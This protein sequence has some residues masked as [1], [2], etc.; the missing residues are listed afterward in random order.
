MN[1][2]DT[3]NRSES[4]DF[5]A[6]RLRQLAA[7]QCDEC[8]ADDEAAE[9]EVMLSASAAARTM[10]VR[11]MNVHAGLDW[12]I[13]SRE[14]VEEMVPAVEAS[15]E[16]LPPLS[17]QRSWPWA[18][19]AIAAGLLIVSSV[20][21]WHTK[22]GAEGSKS[23]IADTSA[24]PAGVDVAAAVTE[25]GPQAKWSVARRDNDAPKQLREGD[26]VSISEGE[27]QVRFDSGVVV[28]LYAPAELE[29]ISPMK[30]KAIRGR[31][32][33]NVVDGAEGFAI[34]T[35]RATV[36][37]QGTVFGV[38]VGD[39]GDTDV[40]VFKGAV[41]LHLDA[42]D[43]AEPRLA[44]Q[45][46]TSGEAMRIDNHGTT[47]RIVSISSDRF[48]NRPD[49]HA[50][51]V[52]RPVLISAVSDNIERGANSWNYYEIV[53]GG[54]NEDAKAFVDRDEHEWN[55]IDPSGMPKFLIGGDYVKTFNN[56][57]FGR[58]IELFVTVEQPCKLYVLLDDRITPPAWLV[59][60]FH[61]TGFDV[62]MDV[63]RFY[64]LW[65]G[66]LMEDRLP[67]VGPGVSV[68]D[69]I[70]IWECDINAPEIVH[71]GATEAA[72]RFVN[73]YGIVAVPLEQ[74]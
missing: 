49:Y 26:V 45:R 54:M 58:D 68:D 6:G 57:K 41:D 62:G 3:I 52:D 7:A 30:G 61:D 9:L 21:V 37:D 25:L 66:K 63:G 60:R 47:S 42:T 14:S 69:T 35:P 16:Q 38:E 8:L 11:Y 59:N 23:P 46:L 20:A 4:P 19:A 74:K 34:V 44:K 67:G 1:R 65:D 33:A 28:T 64:R 50:P 15:R 56:D 48:G 40:F 13:T 71:L 70:S 2:D 27:M 51:K 53:H 32:S 5:D 22:D 17:A 10:Y 18:L 43:G 24:A 36:I 73:M 39:T 29:V 55:G 31:L 72:H 12:E